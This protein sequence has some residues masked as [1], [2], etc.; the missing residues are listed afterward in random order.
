MSVFFFFFTMVW[1]PLYVIES[2][3]FHSVGRLLVETLLDSL[4]L[5]LKTMYRLF[6]LKKVD[7]STFTNPTSVDS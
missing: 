3:I 7:E 5:L 2:W 4:K 6:G 1:R